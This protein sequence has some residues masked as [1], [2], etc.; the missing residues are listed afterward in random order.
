MARDEEISRLL[1]GLDLDSQSFEKQLKNVSK[2]TRNL[3]KDFNIAKK[4]VKDAENELEALENVLKKGQA[5]YDGLSK[6]LELQKKRYDDLY[7]VTEKQSNKYNE[8][9]STMSTLESE[10]QQLTSAENRNE[11]AIKEK[12]QALEKTKTEMSNM[13]DLIQRNAQKL[14]GYSTDINKTENN[15]NKLD[16]EL[17]D[18]KN[19]INNLKVQ[20][21]EGELKSFSQRCKEASEKL[22]DLG[23]KAKG[24][25]DKMQGI[26][27][28]MAALGAG[29]VAGLTQASG[30]VAKIEGSLKM[31]KEEADKTFESVKNLAEK[32]FDFDEMLDGIIKVKQNLGT[33]LSDSEIED[34]TAEMGALS[35]TFDVDVSDSIKAVSM[36]MKNFGISGQEATDI[37][38]YGFQNGLDVS[39]DWIDTLWEYSNQ[40]ADLGFTAEETLA[41]IDNGM[42]AGAFSTDKL[43]DGVKE[44]G[45]RLKDVGKDQ[46]ASLGELGLSVDEVTTAFNEG[47]EAGKNMAINVAKKLM[48]VKDETDR[49][50]IATSLFGTMYE[51]VGETVVRS[52]SEIET[53]QMTVKGSADQVKEAFENS[54]GARMAGMIQELKEPLIQIGEEALLPLMDV[55]IDLAGEFADWLGSMDEDTI[56]AIGT[57]MIFAGALSPLLGLVGSIAKVAGGAAGLFGKL[58]G[59]MTAAGGAASGAAG[60]AGLLSGALALLSGPVGIG[61]AVVALGGLI[62]T[63]G[64]SETALGF[65]QDKFGGLGTVIG[66]VCEFIAGVWDLTIGNLADGAMFL[67]DVL[68]SA[69]DGPGGQTV[70]QSW[71]DYCKKLE[72]RNKDAWDNLTLDTTRNL[73]QQ[74]NDVDKNT[75]DAA[76]KMDQNTKKG[77][78]AVKTNMSQAS[79]AAFDESGKIPK[80]VQANMDA[81]VRSMKQAGSDMYNGIKTSFSK[82]ETVGKQHMTDLYKG[83]KTSAE[84]MAS[85][86]KSAASDMY[87]GVTGS[88]SKMKTRAIADWNAIKDAYSKGIKGTVTITKVNK[89]EKAS[90]D[91]DMSAPAPASDVPMVAMSNYNTNSGFFNLG[92]TRNAFAAAGMT[93]NS[94]LE[95]QVLKQGAAIN[96]LINNLNS[97]ENSINLNIPLNV[98]GRQIARATGKYIKSE[99]SIIEQRTNRLNGI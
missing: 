3:E 22:D 42:K 30:A 88:T 71:E 32:G 55:V 15:L 40:F 33:M 51:D 67:F 78:D 74:K 38:A 95:N 4:A 81:S 41:F 65:L 19:S 99:L 87:N 31:T 48:G 85:S 37:I 17:K 77:A 5:A 86:A 35:K 97:K 34:L 52:L 75:K 66:G 93:K 61:L 98:D 84:K 79:K 2:D 60:G 36:M 57:T 59:S 46:A 54:L 20:Q 26:S 50:R 1:V 24:A 11:E 76:D 29:S 94:I 68:A 56:K 8:L 27:A 7:K 21:A 70:Q 47:G 96:K 49:N 62:S 72:T 43:A 28:G 45:I 18:V 58:S 89:T 10:L 69:I 53:G 12:T 9:K 23:E 91:A 44:F 25:G 64:E 83:T 80:D 92:Q 6:K 14:K 63:I 39:G 13:E 73:S 90:I 82:L 16:R